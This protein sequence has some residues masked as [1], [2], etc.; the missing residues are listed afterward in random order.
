MPRLLTDLDA[1]TAARV[2]ASIDRLDGVPPEILQRI[3]VLLSGAP[4]P[5]VVARYLDRLW[6]EHPQSF[7]RIAGQTATLRYLMAVFSYSTFLSEA[8]LK[9][10]QWLEQLGRAGDMH[11]V[12]MAEEYETR[13]RQ[14]VGWDSDQAP[15]ALEL[16][17]FRREQ[18]L[19]I[20]IRDVL[21]LGTL[22]DV[23][24]EISNLADAILDLSY[25]RIRATLAT[26]HG[27]PMFNG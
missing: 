17:N 26:I 22:S 25:R 20:V 15:S 23:T 8:V 1:R 2:R 13:L 27:E 18:V 21:G 11:R 6:R 24:E 3:G 19:R 12:L 16:A 9:W 7:L 10:P 5:E 4:D 14:F